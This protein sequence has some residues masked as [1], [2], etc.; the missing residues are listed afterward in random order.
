MSTRELNP[1]AQ[2]AAAPEVII[3]GAGVAGL[4]C[5]TLLADHGLRVLVVEADT[6]P[7][8]RARSWVD[9]GTGD[10]VDIGPH[11]LLNKYPNMLAWLERLGTSDQ[12]FWQ[13]RELLTVLDKQR[14]LHFTVSSLPPPLHWLPNLSQILPSV[15]LR[16][17][18]TNTRLGWRTMRSTGEELLALDHLTG[19]DYLEQMGVSKEFIDWFWA[20]AA[21]AFLN[22]PV[23]QCSAASLMRLLA[24]ALGHN[25][26]AFGIPRVGLSDLYAWP[27]IRAVEGRGGVVRLGCRVESLRLRGDRAVG[28][29]LEDGTQ[30]D[31]ASVV[32]AV[33]PT[34]IP[35][36]LPHAYPLTALSLRFEP[37]PYISC[38]LWF[39][40]RITDTPFWARPWSPAEFNT[41]FYD[42]ANVQRE[43]T[44]SLLATNILR[45]DRLAHLSDEQII[46][47]TLREIADFTPLAMQARLVASAVHRIPMAIPSAVP[48]IESSR[49]ATAI[50]PGLWLAG[51]WVDTGLPFCMESAVRAG[52]LAA[53]ALL[54]ERGVHAALVQ[55]VPVPGGLGRLLRG[56]D[57]Q[58]IQGGYNPK[59][60]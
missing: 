7:G 43:R 23:E 44:G 48:G 13:T 14:H 9:P 31:A 28:V 52:A 56:S 37:S 22:T 45:S 47:A 36:L 39:D 55:P 57:P 60:A 42:L 34:A 2:S 20:T 27:A 59:R 12:V 25:D 51:D 11:I 3:I 35:S 40:R 8:G 21:M 29:T 53:E 41:D 50:G 33:P 18:L 19:R 5:A 17:L 15:P 26:V 58:R 49:P 4:A 54:A 16:R 32:L 38:Y 10:T 24:Q 1:Q 46:G 6:I 30:I